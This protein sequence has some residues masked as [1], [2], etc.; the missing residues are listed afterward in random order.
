MRK[1]L[2]VMNV[3]ALGVAFGL[4]LWANTRPEML[5]VEQFDGHNY[6]VIRNGPGWPVRAWATEQRGVSSETIPAES[7]IADPY[8]D[9]RA[10]AHRMVW[11]INGPIGGLL[12]VAL[13]VNL[14]WLFRRAVAD[15]PSRS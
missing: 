5:I 6:R 1:R 9:S 14:H 8:P 12:V 15:P 7:I 13:V 3:I 11:L 4:F 2:A 10:E